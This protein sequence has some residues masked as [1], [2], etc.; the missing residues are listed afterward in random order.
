MRIIFLH[1][2]HFFANV[3]I[4]TGDRGVKN[5]LDVLAH[6]LLYL[7]IMERTSNIKSF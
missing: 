6:V 5:K 4:H 1:P 7:K 3:I 2:E